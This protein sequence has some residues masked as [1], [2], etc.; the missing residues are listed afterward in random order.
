MLLF[1]HY[2][3]VKLTPNEQLQPWCFCYPTSMECNYAQQMDNCSLDA[4]AVTLQQI[5]NMHTKWPTVDLMLLLLHFNGVHLC[6]LN[7]QFQ[8]GCYYCP[9][10]MECNYAQ[11]MNN[12]RIDAIVIPLLR[13]WTIHTII[14]ASVP[15]FVWLPFSVTM[16]TE[17]TIAALMLW[18]S[19][20]LEV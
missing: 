10:A 16:Q 3:G 15:L 17:W 9:T 14:V 19:H 8:P 4:F 2:H 13:V 12:C 11:Q 20:C 1:S 18:L 7:G 5:V 6:T